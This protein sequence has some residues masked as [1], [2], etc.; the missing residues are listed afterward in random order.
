MNPS[1]KEKDQFKTFNDSVKQ[2]DCCSTNYFPVN[3]KQNKRRRYDTIQERI[4]D[5]SRLDGGAVLGECEGFDLL[6]TKIYIG[7]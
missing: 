6:G 3:S 5:N 4:S 7:K 1:I 2:K